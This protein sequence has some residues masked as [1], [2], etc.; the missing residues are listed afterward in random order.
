MDRNKSCISHATC[1]NWEVYSVNSYFI[2]RITLKLLSVKDV[3][4]LHLTLQVDSTLSILWKCTLPIAHKTAVFTSIV[5]KWQSCIWNWLL[6]F[7]IS[8]PAAYYF[9]NKY[10]NWHWNKLGVTRQYFYLQLYHHPSSF[11]Y[12][13]ACKRN[14]VLRGKGRKPTGFFSI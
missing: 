1:D 7:Y 8:I 2:L 12:F 9:E 13:Q 11:E 5:I 10:K 4:S 14:L 3:L 6:S